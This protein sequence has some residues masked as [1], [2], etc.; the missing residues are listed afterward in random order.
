MNGQSLYCLDCWACGEM[1]QLSAR[2]DQ[3]QCPNCDAKLQL[4]WHIE[5]AAHDQTAA[6]RTAS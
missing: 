2:D 1:I 6:L 3:R 4:E 5:R